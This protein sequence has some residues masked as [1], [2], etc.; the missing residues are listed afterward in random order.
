VIT[1]WNKWDKDLTSAAA[2]RTGR[3]W[4]ERTEKLEYRDQVSLG[5]TPQNGQWVQDPTTPYFDHWQE[6][7]ATSQ[8]FREV[9]EPYRGELGTTV[10]GQQHFTETGEG[11]RL[12]SV[13]AKG[14]PSLYTVTGVDESSTKHI[15]QDNHTSNIDGVSET[16]RG[17]NDYRRFARLHTKATVID[18]YTRL[19]WFDQ[20]IDT[21]I[22]EGVY[23]KTV[24]PDAWIEVDNHQYERYFVQLTGAPDSGSGSK[25]HG[26]NLTASF[27]STTDPDWETT[28]LPWGD[29]S[30]KELNWPQSQ[31]YNPA[32]D[33]F[34]IISGVGEIVAGVT[35][36]LF[37][38]ET[39]VGVVGGVALIAMGVDQVLTGVHNI[40]YGRVGHGFS[41]AEYGVYQVTGSVTAAVLIPAAAAFVFS[42]D[43]YRLAT[44]AW[45]LATRGMANGS[46]LGLMVFGRTTRPGGPLT[47]SFKPPF[48]A[49]S[50][51]TRTS[52]SP[53]SGAS[54]L[55][56]PTGS[57]T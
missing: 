57:C 21:T 26:G 11:Y 54:W 56:H 17:L 35:V 8:S 49:S 47:K 5:A 27:R 51:G 7:K 16:F 46:E 53:A 3:E 12:V 41:V 40:R 39:G 32:D 55:S 23:L 52:P 43:A 38:A 10:V 19:D 2:G 24:W 20:K 18:G 36:L 25:Q 45:R 48:S 14:T 50:S 29:Q 22:N 31:Y 44:G 6:A 9:T 30:S 37:T 28:T 4:L 13:A 1:S 15:V 33:Y 34:R 42:G